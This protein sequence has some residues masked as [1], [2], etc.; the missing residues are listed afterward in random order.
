MTEPT[1]SKPRRLGDPI[2]RAVLHDGTRRVRAPRCTAP[3]LMATTMSFGGITACQVGTVFA[4]RTNRASLR[5]IGVLTNR[6][7]RRDPIPKGT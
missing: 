3:Y 6:L 2:E 5:E 4:A 7:L 1:H